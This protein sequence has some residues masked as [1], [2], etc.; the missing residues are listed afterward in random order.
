MVFSVVGVV[1]PALTE[2]LSSFPVMVEVDGNR[3]KALRG[4]RCVSSSSAICRLGMRARICWLSTNKYTAE[5]NV[6]DS[7]DTYSW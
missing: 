5:T 3:E 4:S 1:V 6:Q 7:Y 2:L